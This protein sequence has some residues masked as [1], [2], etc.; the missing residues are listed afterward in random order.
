[1]AKIR[2]WTIGRTDGDPRHWIIPTKQSVEKLRELLLYIVNNGTRDI[3]WDD[4][5]KCTI[6]DEG[7]ADEI[8]VPVEK[9]DNGEV[10]YRLIKKEEVSGYMEQNAEQDNS[11][12]KMPKT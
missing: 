12:D 2:L 6:I 5:L 10:L 3:I 7:E 4:T 1:M 11:N 8:L 9:L